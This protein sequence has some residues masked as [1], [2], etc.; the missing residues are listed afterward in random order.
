MSVGSWYEKVCT[1]HAN[2]IFGSCRGIGMY[3]MLQWCFKVAR[4]CLVGATLLVVQTQCQF[5]KQYPLVLLSCFPPCTTNTMP[6][7]HPSIG[8]V[9][10]LEI[11]APRDCV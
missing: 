5:L 2:L 10:T 8:G 6:H 3:L 9:V 7:V 1:T 4:L 11:W